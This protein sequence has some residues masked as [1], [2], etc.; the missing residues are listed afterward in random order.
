MKPVLL[1]VH[2]WGFDAAFW[3]PLRA[4]LPSV[5]TVVSDAGYFGRPVR[6]ELPAGRPVFAAG[7]SMGLMD[8]LAAPPAG[9][10]GLVSLGGF[11]RFV[12]GPGFL[13]GVH[14]LLLGRMIGRFGR[15]PEATL[16]DFRR[17]AGAGEAP[18]GLDAPCL[19]AGLVRLRDG[20]FRE[21]LFRLGADILA[22]AATDDRVVDEAMSRAAWGDRLR[23]RSDGGHAFP[24]TRPGWCAGLITE[25]MDRP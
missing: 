19:A 6:P 10:A 17:L 22:L 5:D 8:I 24:A 2:G 12:R 16:A 13:E 7:H 14:P 3:K 11:A 15:E 1:L 9:L 4:A 20:D 23:V 25:F 18:A 21:A